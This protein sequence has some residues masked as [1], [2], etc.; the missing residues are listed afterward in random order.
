M[1]V[2]RSHLSRPLCRF[3]RPSPG[4]NPSHT[5]TWSSPPSWRRSGCRRWS[6]CRRTRPRLRMERGWQVSHIG[7]SH[8]NGAIWCEGSAATQAVRLLSA[9]VALAV[10]AVAGIAG[11]H[12]SAKMVR[13]LLLTGGASAHVII[14]IDSKWQ[15]HSNDLCVFWLWRDGFRGFKVNC[16]QRDSGTMMENDTIHCKREPKLF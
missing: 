4:R 12:H 10:V 13:A 15:K 1:K 14:C 9:T 5:H 2:S 6:S 16:V 7:S 8:S 11:A 3:S